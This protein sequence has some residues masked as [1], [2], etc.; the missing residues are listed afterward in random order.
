MN[1][2]LK[3]GILLLWIACAVNLVLPFPAPWQAILLWTGG[4]LLVTHAIECAVFASRITRAG[5]NRAMHFIQV[6]LFGVIH[7]QTLPR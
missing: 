1:V 4:I 2:I 6:L 3:I 7:A 5:G